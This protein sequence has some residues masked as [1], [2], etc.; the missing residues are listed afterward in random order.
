MLDVNIKKILGN[1]HLNIQFNVERGIVGILGPSGCGKSLTLQAIAGLLKPDSGTISIG[2]RLLFDNEKNI[3]VPTRARKIGYVFQNYALFP[4][5]SVAENISYG[6]KEHKKQ[7]RQRKV[8]EMLQVVQLS[9]LENRYPDELSGGQ[10][11]RVALARTLVT[12]PDILLL[13]EPFSALDQHVKKRLEL[14]LL[15]IIKQNF[16]GVVL[17]VTHNIEEAYRLCD[18]ICLYD[19]GANIQYGKKEDVLQSPV[20]RAAAQIVGCENI[21]QIDTVNDTSIS[22]NRLELNLGRPVQS[23]KKHIGIHSH[24]VT[25]VPRTNSQNTFNYTITSIVE[26]IDHSTVSVTINSLTVKVNVPKSTVA[27]ICKGDLMLYIPPEKL[28]LME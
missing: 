24:D 21:Y 28:F 18:H 12:K 2:D 3:N 1:F 11:Q 17:F 15:D 5:L 16:A 22:V 19:R 8:T 7:D 14:E 23:E 26:G 10:Q 6:L 20:S 27:E 4:H 25:F 9:G 13:D